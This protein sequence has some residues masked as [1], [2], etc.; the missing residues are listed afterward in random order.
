V[1]IKKSE[2]EAPKTKSKIHKNQKSDSH[3]HSRKRKITNQNSATDVP[4]KFD[5]E[6]T[7]FVAVEPTPTRLRVG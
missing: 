6:Q 3:E 4:K 5:G 7:V 2:I 1:H